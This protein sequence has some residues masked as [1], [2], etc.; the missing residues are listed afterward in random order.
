MFL[1]SDELV[2]LTGFKRRTAQARWLAHNG[3]RFTV[4]GLGEPVVAIAEMSRRMVSG[5]SAAGARKEP[6]YGVLDG[7]IAKA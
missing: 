1:T 3:W 2:A 6:N 5:A 7:Q 4:N